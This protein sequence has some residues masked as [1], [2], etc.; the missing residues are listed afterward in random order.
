MFAGSFR[1]V[2]QTVP[3]AIYE[4][5]STDFTGALA[6]SAVLVCVSA[7]LL[8]AVKLSRASRRCCALRPHD[9]SGRWRSTSRS[10]S[11]RGDASRW[12]ARRARARRPCCRSSPACCGRSAGVVALRR[13]GLARHRARDRR[14]RPS[15][16]RCGYVFQDYA[17]FG[18]LSAWQQRRLRL[19][20][21]ARG[22]RAASARSEL[23]ER[24]GLGALRRRPA[25]AALR[26]RAP[27]R[28]AGPG[29]GARPAGAA[30]RRAAVRA[31]RAHARGRRARAGRRAARRR[32]P[33]AARHARLRRGGAARR[34][35]RRRS[36]AGGSSS[37]ATRRA[38]LPP[39]GV[40]VRGRLH[41]RGRA[42]RR[43]HAGRGRLTRWRSTAA[44]IVTRRRARRAR[45]RSA[46]TR[47]R[48]CSSRRHAADPGSARN[49]LA[50]EV[51]SITEVGGRVRVGLAGRS[52]SSPRSPTPP[53][54]SSSSA[55][56]RVP[57]RRGRPRRP[58][59]CR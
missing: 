44:A 6:L 24:F 9:G 25:R 47:G 48:S 58:G 45:S 35:R 28:G 54:A 20:R 51:V 12:R 59:C 1:G 34:P 43:R 21:P 56:A 23:L 13:G 14:A 57:W 10:R 11:P 8:L 18:H 19:T 3:L 32:R 53:C 55:R 26:R 41:R 2:T 5:F 49:H 29:A 16:A 37:S 42:D 27:A 36:T 7:A 38:T 39:A 30:A 52:R 33:G 31:R 4:R 50:V 40:G 17:L 15:G 46:S 22:A